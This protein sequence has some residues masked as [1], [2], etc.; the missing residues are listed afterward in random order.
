MRN[1]ERNPFNGRFVS[2]KSD[3]ERFWTR[4]HKLVARPGYTMARAEQ[5]AADEL[6]LW[7]M[8]EDAE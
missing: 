8:L 4:V 3:E 6:K 5:Q 2:P 1:N 7:H